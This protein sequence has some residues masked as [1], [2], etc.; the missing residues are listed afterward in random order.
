[1]A[2]K[3]YGNCPEHRD[4]IDAIEYLKDPWNKEKL[5]RL[6]S[7]GSWERF[8]AAAKL[9][10]AEADA[11]YADLSQLKTFMAM[12][13]K[14]NR[15][16]FMK[17]FPQVKQDLEERI[18]KLYA[19][20]DEVDKVHRDCTI[21]QVAAASTGAVSGVLTIAG[22]CLA[23]FT[24]GASLAVSGVGLGLGAAAAVTGVTANIVEV[25]KNGSAKAEAK[26]I[27]STGRNLEKVVERILFQCTPKIVSLA[28]RCFPLLERILEKAGVLNAEESN[29]INLDKVS[30][31]KR[32]GTV[33]AQSGLQAMKAL[34][35][36]ARVFGAA[37]AGVFLIVDVVDLVKNSVHLHKGAKAQSAEE[38]RQQAQELE[39]RLEQ[40]TLIHE[41]LQENLSP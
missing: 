14:E 9:S 29:S 1:M 31:F 6:L 36:G 16:R 34:G 24:L 12:E 33:F 40:L 41:S 10:R 3:V 35:K 4:F 25:S 39:R 17:E 15:E 8:V 5:Q 37:T 13:D 2:S 27:E 19:L 30:G 21:T 20:A 22:V 11:L 18:G 32:M 38:L 28:Q 7:D 23:P 26:R